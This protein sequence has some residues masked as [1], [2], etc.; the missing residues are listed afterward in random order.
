MIARQDAE[1]ECELWGALSRL[2]T[3]GWI[4]GHEEAKKNMMTGHSSNEKGVVKG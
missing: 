2:L 4:G 1:W 3:A